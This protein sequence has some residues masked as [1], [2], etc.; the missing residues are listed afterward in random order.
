MECMGELV[1]GW[2]AESG[3]SASA[4]ARRA[5]VSPSTVHRV[6]NGQVD[7][8]LGTLRDI[9]LACG[10]DLGLSARATSDPY[11]A[12]AA[13]AMLEEGYDAPPADEVQAWVER[14]PRLAETDGPVGL[15]EAAAAASAPLMRP[16]AALFTGTTTL[17]RVASAG[18]ASKAPWAI[19]G[20]AG[21]YLPTPG[22]PLPRVTILWTADPR[23]SFHLLADAELK[24]THRPDRAALAVLAAEPALFHG[25]FNRGLVRYAAPIQIVLDCISQGGTVGADAIEEAMSW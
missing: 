3:R 22:D 17:G 25:A 20:A 23:A 10:V 5:G 19:S 16:G 7:P 11:A 13:R 1:R 18:D 8:S 21:L 6:V 15:V 9:A 4:V 12:A 2:I 24:P 14:L